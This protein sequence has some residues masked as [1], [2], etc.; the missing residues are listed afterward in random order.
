MRRDTG[1]GSGAQAD[2]EAYLVPLTQAVEQNEADWR[3]NL[4]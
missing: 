4:Q 2:F 3:T 1:D